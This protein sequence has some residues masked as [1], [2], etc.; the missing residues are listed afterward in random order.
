MQKT[1]SSKV[2]LQWRREYAE[3]ERAYQ[4]SFERGLLF[5]KEQL[6]KLSRNKKSMIPNSLSL[7]LLEAQLRHFYLQ[8]VDLKG[9]SFGESSI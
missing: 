5:Y 7:V 6:S 1:P 9:E 8:P 4:E 2:L 3:F